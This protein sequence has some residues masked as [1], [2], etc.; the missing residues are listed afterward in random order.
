MDF[1]KRIVWEW[2]VWLGMVG[3]CSLIIWLAVTRSE[4][5]AKPG[6][7]V[8]QLNR[9]QVRIV[10]FSGAEPQAAESDGPGVVLDCG[11]ETE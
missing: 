3:Y 4:A 9:A 7:R 6:Y 2:V 5:M 11:G 10:C 8:E 1:K